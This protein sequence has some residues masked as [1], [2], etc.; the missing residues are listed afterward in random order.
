MSTTTEILGDRASRPCDIGDAHGVALVCGGPGLD[1][2]YL[3]DIHPS[4][5]M[6]LESG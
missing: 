4:W 6:R 2:E 1:V 3:L 5:I